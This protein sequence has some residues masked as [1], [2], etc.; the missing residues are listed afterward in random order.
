MFQALEQVFNITI[1]KKDGT[2]EVDANSV[3]GHSGTVTKLIPKQYLDLMHDIRE[4]YQISGGVVFYPPYK[5]FNHAKSL[6]G[7]VVDFHKKDPERLYTPEGN[8][9]ILGSHIHGDVDK[10]WRLLDEKF[11]LTPVNPLIEWSESF[12]QSDCYMRITRKA[13]YKEQ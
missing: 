13:H 10:F 5:Q 7:L 8:Y 4:L 1:I 3:S 6:D 12:T 11:E 9:I 2:V